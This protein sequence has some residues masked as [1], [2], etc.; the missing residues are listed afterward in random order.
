MVEAWRESKRELK[1][2]GSGLR[3]CDFQ[4]FKLFL[5]SK[6]A[7]AVGDNANRICLRQIYG[8]FRDREMV[9]RLAEEATSGRIKISA[10]AC[11]RV[12][13]AALFAITALFSNDGARLLSL[14]SSFCF[15][16]ELSAL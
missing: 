13:S 11:N 15:M 9:H 2:W 6:P 4:S 8:S 16:C 12:E 1:S 14:A 5:K 7:N 3:L 10:R